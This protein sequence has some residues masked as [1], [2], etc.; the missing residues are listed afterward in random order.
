M[1]PKRFLIF[2]AHPDDP[3]I[4]FGGTA[5][6]L[7][8][9]GHLVKFVSLTNGCCGHQS[10][11]CEAL[12]RRRYEETQAAKKTIALAE[13]QVLL[14][15]NDCELEPTLENRRKVIRIIRDFQPDLVLCHRLCDYHADHRAAGQLVQDA[16]YLTQVPLFCP[17]APITPKNPVFGCVYDTFQD[18]RPFRVDAAVPIDDVLEEKCRLMDCQVSQ[19]YEWLPYD[20]GMPLPDPAQMTWNEK[21]AFLNEH[22]GNFYQVTSDTMRQVLAESYGETGRHAQYAECFELSPYGR[23]VTVQEF[24]DLLKP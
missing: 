6:S 3:D 19:F 18:P 10:M 22:W 4:C 1:T 17:D 12:A 20:M 13:Y 14:E 21:Q 24:R 7:I 23:K 15:N 9:A 5:I 2:G 11:S 16:A 8:R